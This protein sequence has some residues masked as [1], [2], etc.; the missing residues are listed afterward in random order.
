MKKIAVT[1]GDTAGVGPIV[2]AAVLRQQPELAARICVLG[3]CEWVEDIARLGCDV[4]AVG[5]AAM[6]E[7]GCPDRRSAGQALA[8]LER[9]TLGCR[10]G[11]YESVVTGPVSKAGLREIGFGYPGQTEYFA[12][13]WGGEP[14]MAFTSP[15]LQVVLA[16]WHEPLA[17]V[18]EALG[19]PVAAHGGVEGHPLAVAVRRAGTLGQLMGHARPRIGVAGLNPHAGEGGLMGDAEVRVL[20]PLLAE[21]GIHEGCQPADTLFHRARSGEYDVVVA[22]THDQGLI[23]V[24]TLHFH[25]AVNVTLGLPWLRCSPDHG[26]AFALAARGGADVETGSMRAALAFALRAA[27]GKELKKQCF[28]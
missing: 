28:R 3:P 20:N 26:T 8:A 11:W 4:E 18:A 17:A 13:R 24:K 5:E 10:E 19:Q 27:E 15:S 25:E 16:T 2:I 1:C 22:L 23:A 14:S 6:P 12:A 21:L 7:R 9:A